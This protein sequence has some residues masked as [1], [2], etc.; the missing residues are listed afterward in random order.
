MRVMGVVYVVAILIA[1]SWVGPL[2]GSAHAEQSAVPA[3]PEAMGT[4]PKQGMPRARSRQSP[5]ERAKQ[6]EAW[7]THAREVLFRDIQ[8]SPEQVRGVDAIVER[9]EKGQQQLDEVRT[10]IQAAQKARDSKRVGELRAQLRQGR[11]KL[12]SPQA[13][14]DEMRALMSDA[15]RPTFDL[16]RAHLVAE[17]QQSR[18]ARQRKRPTR[19]GADAA[20]TGAEAQ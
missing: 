11:A 14:I 15:Q 5:A 19:P 18:Q 3:A 20:G 8:L 12:K 10:E 7:W 2:A 17:R 13:R 9:Q 4:A 16:N 6:R 1:I